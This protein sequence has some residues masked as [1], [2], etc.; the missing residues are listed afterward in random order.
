MQLSQLAYLPPTDWGGSGAGLL[1]LL[2]R[3]VLAVIIAARCVLIPV[4]AASDSHDVSS[5]RV[6]STLVDDASRRVVTT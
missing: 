3:K 2:G 6:E 5:R 1:M 4:C